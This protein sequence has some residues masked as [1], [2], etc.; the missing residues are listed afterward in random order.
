MLGYAKS[1]EVFM[2]LHFSRLAEKDR[3]HYAAVE[4]LKLGRGGIV[5]I[6]R[7]FGIDKNTI[8]LGRAEL[9]STDSNSQLPAGRQ[10]KPGGGRK[11][12]DGSS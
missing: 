7:L 10:R 11:K 3:R 5:Y 9:L 6:S 12:K 2:Q 1:I 4:A 8:N